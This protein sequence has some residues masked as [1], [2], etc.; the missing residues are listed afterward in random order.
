[1]KKEKIKKNK[2]RK[3]MEKFIKDKTEDNYEER[4]KEMEEK[5]KNGKIRKRM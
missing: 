5:G 3:R 1:M 4:C 2:K